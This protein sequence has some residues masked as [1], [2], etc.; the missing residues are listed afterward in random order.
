MLHNVFVYGFVACKSARIFRR[1]PKIVKVRGFSERKIRSNE[2]Y[3]VLPTVIL[4]RFIINIR[5]VIIK[6]KRGI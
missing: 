1:K 2:L 4:F 3:T 5:Y 6:I